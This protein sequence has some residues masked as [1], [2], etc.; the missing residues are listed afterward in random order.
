[1]S[2]QPLTITEQGS[3][4]AGGKTIQQEGEYRTEN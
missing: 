1:M 2:K 3:F 4:F